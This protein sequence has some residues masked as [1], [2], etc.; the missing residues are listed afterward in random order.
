MLRRK[1]VYL[2][3]M[4]VILCI[5]IMYVEYAPYIVLMIMIFLPLILYIYIFVS[6]KLI[7]VHT[8]I[9]EQSVARGD[10]IAFE[11]FVN[12]IS[13]FPA[14]NITVMVEYKYNNCNESMYKQ[15]VINAKVFEKTRVSGNMMLNYCGNLSIGI[16]KAYIYDPL[17]IFK[18][19]IQCDDYNH[20]I[21]MPKLVEPDNYTLYT[22]DNSILDSSYYSKKASGNDSSQIF[23]TREYKDGDSVSRIHW[24]LSAKQDKVIVKEF[25]MPIHKSNVILVELFGGANEQQR[26]NL[27]GV[28]EMA[29]A[30]GNFAC[31]KESAFKLVF[32][33]NHT[34]GLKTIDI[35]SKDSLIDAIHILIEEETYSDSPN[36]LNE[37]QIADMSEVQRVYYI[38]SNI[39]DEIIEFLDEEKDTNFLIYSMEDGTRESE[40]FKIKGA[41]LFNVDR[42]DI[43]QCLNTILI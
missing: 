36:A 41:M 19:S 20:I 32:Y 11:I 31:I 17:K 21:V 30:I 33:S 28:Y 14:P 2:I 18:C 1:I 7:S 42:D 4:V 8:K 13:I 38:T 27:D 43:K 40:S 35:K 3:S 15:F 25:S 24:K 6:S 22:P 5:N 39:S 37:F 9:E 10:K 29:Y 16:K 23:D 34:N 26:K 12:N